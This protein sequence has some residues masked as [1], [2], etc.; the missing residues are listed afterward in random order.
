MNYK[1]IAGIAMIALSLCGMIFW[2]MFGREALT[3]ETVVVAAADIREGSVVDAASFRLAKLPKDSVIASSVSWDQAMALSG[4]VARID[5]MENQQ[6]D[7]SAFTEKSRLISE[8]VSI[9]SIPKEWIY[10][11]PAGL[12]AGDGVAIYLMPEEQLLGSFTIAYLRD[13]SEQA[14]LGTGKNETI[15]SRNGSTALVNS[16]EIL[17]STSS[18]FKIFDAMMGNDD[19]SINE[20]A[21][22][23]AMEKEG[24]EDPDWRPPRFSDP[25]ERSLLLVLQAQ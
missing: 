11:R 13:S 16:V 14:V 12:R 21:R 19:A 8:G 1:N 9:F 20:E 23:K 3:L 2:E 6:I 5:I 7:V 22:A 18:Y 24:K 25:M 10:S 17:A 4:K 15:L